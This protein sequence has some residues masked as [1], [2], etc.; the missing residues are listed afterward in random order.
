M[1]EDR[2]SSGNRSWLEKLVQPFAQEPRSRQE[3][4]EVLRTAQRNEV[5]DLEALSII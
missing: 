3:L 2:P 5:L 4:L 1:S